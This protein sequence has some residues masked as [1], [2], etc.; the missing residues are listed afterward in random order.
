MIFK[1]KIYDTKPKIYPIEVKSGKR[2]KTQ[3]LEKFISQYRQRIGR[4]YIIR[5]KNL[6]V[7][8]DIICIPSYMTMCL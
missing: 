3:S 1:R 4:A 5:P 2:Y 6:F 7:R 8:N